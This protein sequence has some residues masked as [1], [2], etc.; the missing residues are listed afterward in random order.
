MNNTSAKQENKSYQP[1]TA[2]K[3]LSLISDSDW[4]IEATIDELV[5]NLATTEQVVTNDVGQTLTIRRYQSQCRQ[6]ARLI[7]IAKPAPEYLIYSSD[8]KPEV[9]KNLED[10]IWGQLS[11]HRL[12][13]IILHQAVLRL[14]ESLGF[15]PYLSIGRK[16]KVKLIENSNG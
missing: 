1:K 11:H 14:F 13:E 6:L 8:L 9:R 7:P 5:C 2:E 16:L 10:G 15:E 4:T 12:R 3:S